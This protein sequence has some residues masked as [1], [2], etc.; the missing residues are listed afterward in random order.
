MISYIGRNDEKLMGEH[1]VENFKYDLSIVAIIKGEESYLD[2]W[3]TYH[4]IVGCSHFY[5]FDNEDDN[6]K[7]KIVLEKYVKQGVVTYIPFTGHDK[8]IEAYDY[9]CKHFSEET[10]YM[11]LIDADE[12]IF[13]THGERIDILVDSLFRKYSNYPYLYRKEPAAI[14]VNW[15]M[16]GTSNHK[17]RP[18]GGVLENFLLRAPDSWEENYHVKN[19]VNPR[20]VDQANVHYCRYKS[21]YCCISENGSEITGPFFP[22][23]RCSLI[24]INH[25]RFKSEEE[26]ISRI[27]RGWIDPNNE[28]KQ[29]GS[30]DLLTTQW[31]WNAIYDP[32]A[33][34]YIEAINS[35]RIY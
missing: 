26:F 32:I 15:R 2:E 34:P 16:Y 5:L 13:S 30:Y 20:C 19:I 10:K 23:G 28:S 25:Y 7:Q 8:Q 27:E 14:G 1:N 4:K 31:K 6:D 24:R 12:F 29:K 3:I 18:I 35:M 9:A 33:L 11:A 21:G 22:D 17:Q